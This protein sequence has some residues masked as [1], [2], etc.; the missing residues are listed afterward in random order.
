M[1][2]QVALRQQDVCCR[3]SNLVEWFAGTTLHAQMGCGVPK[4]K[5]DF[6]KMFQPN[7]RKRWRSLK[8]RSLAARPLMCNGIPICSTPH[9]FAILP[10]RDA[11]M[12]G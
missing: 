10:G 5:E 12:N 7:V 9:V 4:T 8:V 11:E 6:G 3:A 1:M 2:G